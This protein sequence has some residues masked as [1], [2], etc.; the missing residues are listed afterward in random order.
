MNERVKKYYQGNDIKN[1][2]DVKEYV[3]ELFKD[4]LTYERIVKIKAWEIET[5]NSLLAE[6]PIKSFDEF[7]YDMSRE[8]VIKYL[9]IVDIDGWGDR[10]FILGK[11][12]KYHDWLDTRGS[13]KKK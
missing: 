2:D 13:K 3:N 5:L 1:S 12:K 8:D 9:Y 10:E 7:S 4:A 6:A 11:I